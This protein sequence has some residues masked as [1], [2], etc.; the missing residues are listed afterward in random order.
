MTF[1]CIQKTYFGTT[2]IKNLIDKDNWKHYFPSINEIFPDEIREIQHDVMAS[3]VSLLLRV[4]RKVFFPFINYLQ[5]VKLSLLV[6]L[7]NFL[8]GGNTKLYKETSHIVT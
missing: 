8:Q 2:P 4:W 5:K 6:D 1:T 7:I 3:S